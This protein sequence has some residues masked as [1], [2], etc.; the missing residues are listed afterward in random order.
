MVEVGAKEVSEKDVEDLA[1]LSFV[2]IKE[3]IQWQKEILKEFKVEKIEV[4]SPIDSIPEEDKK[5]I[6]EFINARLEQAMFGESE[7]R[8]KDKTERV[9]RILFFCE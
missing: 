7:N 6:L 8:P 5:N 1:E 3:L 9:G 4:K 2:K